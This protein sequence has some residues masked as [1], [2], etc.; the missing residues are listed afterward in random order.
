MGPALS[1]QFPQHR[2][3]A[4]LRRADLSV[5]RWLRGCDVEVGASVSNARV[6][7]PVI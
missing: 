5:G 3:P 2:Q 4:S 1:A 7:L 6:R